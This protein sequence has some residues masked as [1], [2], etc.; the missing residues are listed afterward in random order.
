VPFALVIQILAFIGMV[1]V[2]VWGWIHVPDEARIHARAGTSGFDWTMSKKTT[3]LW[4]PSIGA[5]IGVA[6]FSARGSDTG[7]TIARLGAALMVIF[8][9]AHA[10]SV[11]RAA[12]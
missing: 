9:A 5:L 6:T 3:L 7:T 2:S 12:R 11:R 1:A 8:L 4:T 10:S